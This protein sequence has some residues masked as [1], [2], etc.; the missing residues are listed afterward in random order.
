M[1]KLSRPMPIDRKEVLLLEVI[2]FIGGLAA[3]V[4]LKAGKKK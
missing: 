1:K 2:T 3:G 4:L